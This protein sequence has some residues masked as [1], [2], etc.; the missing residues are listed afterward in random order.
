LHSINRDEC[1]TFDNVEEHWIDL[2]VT[3]GGEMGCEFVPFGPLSR[4]NHI[5]G[6]FDFVT[7]LVFCVCVLWFCSPPL[8]T[9]I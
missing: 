6:F 8:V 5:M 7:H 3:D 4:E 1:G 2:S 9:L